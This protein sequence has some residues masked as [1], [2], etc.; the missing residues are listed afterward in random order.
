MKISTIYAVF[1]GLVIALPSNTTDP[2][3]IVA[4]DGEFT[5]VTHARECLQSI[6]FSEEI[7]QKTIDALLKTLR[8]YTFKDI[9][10]GF[11]EGGPHEVDVDLQDGLEKMAVKSYESDHEF[12]NDVYSLFTSL[13]DA[14]T[15]YYSKCHHSGWRFYQPFVLSSKVK[16]GEQQSIFIKELVFPDKATSFSRFWEKAIGSLG[17]Y[18]GYTVLEIDGVEAVEAIRNFANSEVGRCRDE[19]VRFNLALG[20]YDYSSG[21]YRKFFGLFSERLS[22]LLPTADFVAYKLL[23]PDSGLILDL[24]I[25][26]LTIR[27]SLKFASTSEYNSLMCMNPTKLTR[28]STTKSSAEPEPQQQ[29]LVSPARTPT[30]ELRQEVPLIPGLVVG[31]PDARVIMPAQPILITGKS[32]ISAF[33][34]LDND[35]AVFKVSSFSPPGFGSSYYIFKEWLK[36]F[37]IVKAQGYTNLIL[38]VQSN[39]GGVICLGTAL[40]RYLFPSTHDHDS[41]FISSPL[42]HALADYGSNNSDSL[43]SYSHWKDMFDMSYSDSSFFS[44]GPVIERGMRFS[45]YTKK[46]RLDCSSL[47]NLLPVN[48]STGP[49]NVSSLAILSNGYCG[50]TC[51]LFTTLL[52]ELHGVATFAAGGLAKSKEMAFNSFAG[53]QVYQLQ[54]L[55]SDISSAELESREDVPESFPTKAVFSFTLREVYSKIHSHLPA[56]FTWMPADYRLFVDRFDPVAAWTAVAAKWRGKKRKFDDIDGEQ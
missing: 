45:Q 14:H 31:N 52:K 17:E 41:D 11:D 13:N 37:H 46:A 33:Y 43:F 54:S 21:Q 56:E 55:L 53:G 1:A 12:H 40:A 28:A 42:L 23:D 18:E 9:S 44:T 51:S 16:D 6:P 5:T 15:R 39:G 24:N 27:P 25:P 48:V 34:R 22:G 49:F 10:I 20:R 26:F 38:D 32:S 8:F 19:N 29:V 7:R 3:G 30:Q 36:G 50:S 2:C 35:T 47:Y 4:E